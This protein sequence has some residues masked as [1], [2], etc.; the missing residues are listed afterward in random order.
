MQTNKTFTMSLTIRIQ[1]YSVSY[2]Y[3]L[4]FAMDC[5][6]LS[7][8][9]LRRLIGQPVSH[10]GTTCHVIEVLADGPSLVLQD[11][12]GNT[13]LQDDRFG[14]PGRLVPRI[15]T[16]PLRDDSGNALHPDFARLGLLTGD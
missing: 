9:Q 4:V 6:H 13:D 10:R 15:Y 16:I 8:S 2:R 7:L 3:T 12:G 1:L 14:E 11:A 5:S